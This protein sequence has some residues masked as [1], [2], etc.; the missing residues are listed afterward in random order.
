MELDSFSILLIEANERDKDL[1]RDIIVQIK[2]L[3]LEF[4]HVKNIEEAKSKLGN[5]KINIILLGCTLGDGKGMNNLKALHKEDPGIPIVMLLDFEDDSFGTETLQAG[6]Q[7]YAAKWALNK[8]LMTRIIKHA[9]ER[10]K[11]LS[12]LEAFR[13]QQLTESEER[14]KSL[15][16]NVPVGLYRTTPEG[17]VI[18]ANPTLFKMLGYSSFDEMAKVNLNEEYFDETMN[19]E[20][21]IKQIE[22]KN[23]IDDHEAKWKC[24]DGRIMYVRE[25][26]KAI[27]NTEGK[28][29][30]FEGTVQDYT[31]RKL[32]EQ[33]LTRFTIELKRSNEELEDFASI[34]SHDLKEPL[35]KVIAFCERLSSYKENFDEDGQLYLDRMKASVSRMQ[36]LI[37]DLLEYSRIT[38][39]AHPFQNTNL[40]QV[41][42][43]VLHDLEHTIQAK[44]G[45]V[46]V[47]E[48]PT[49]ES[50]S[51]QMRQ[52]FQNLISNGLKY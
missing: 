24:L 48:L 28:I 1:V 23:E 35:R 2:E 39:K 11:I 9:V 25:S 13:N 50:D 19:R 20:D 37:D 18:L 29:M 49:I 5:N 34:A 51:L 31:K 6:A 27:R 30:Y 15:F 7:D 26:A 40:N 32:S 44:N 8:R 42:K 33:Q 38:T 36:Q 21:F 22:E 10:H 46:D 52:L 14:F 47:E 41:V 3:H 4:D 45:K 12:E 16:E 43:H 17:E